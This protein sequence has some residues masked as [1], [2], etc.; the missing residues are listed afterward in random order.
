MKKPAQNAYEVQLAAASPVL[1]I[2]EAAVF[3]HASVPAIRKLISSGA[4]AYQRLGKRFLVRRADLEQ[5]LE[6][7]WRQVKYG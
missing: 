3:A 1:T 4:L 2:P 5:V 7:G 6:Q